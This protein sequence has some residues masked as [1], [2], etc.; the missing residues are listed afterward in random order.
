[1]KV[2]TEE[3]Y[4][5]E[6]RYTTTK[7]IASDGKEFLT[8]DGCLKHEEDLE[9]AKHPVFQNAI[10]NVYTYYDDYQANMYY[11]SNEDDY[12]FL[13]KHLGVRR[14][15]YIGDF[16]KYGSGWYLYWV[17]D[18]GDYADYYYLYNYNAYVEA[19]EIELKHW[20][21]NIKDRM[22]NANESTI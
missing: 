21:E 5:P 18:G 15:N 4:V 6:K 8:E 3:H 17:E 11:I 7:Y 14:G 1:M 12:K 9:V 13:I 22:L 20:K 19:I 10:L 2:V 16:Y